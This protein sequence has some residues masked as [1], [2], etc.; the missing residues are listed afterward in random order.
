MGGRPGWRIGV[1]LVAAV[2]GML[3]VTTARTAEGTD[4][5]AERRTEL[6]DLIRAE[7][8]RVSEA[9]QEVQRLRDDVAALTG[10]ED[11][12][13]HL[14]AQARALATAAGLTPVQGPGVTVRLDDAPVPPDGIPDG[15]GGDDFVVHQQD[16]QGVVNALLAG[17]ADAVAVMDRR[18]VS[19]GALRCVGNTLIID[20]QVF[21]PPY[22]VTAVGPIDAMLRSLD[23]DRSVRVYRQWVDLVGL[24]YQVTTHRVLRVPG[25]EGPQDIR[26]AEPVP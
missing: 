2:A 10:E 15:Y 25:Y 21:A 23:D 24:G 14:A 6:A 11:D 12:S 9:L 16:V 8:S 20:G 19:T 22:T 4:L 18:L 26:F 5:R 13:G 3:F 7:Q 1:G 17:G